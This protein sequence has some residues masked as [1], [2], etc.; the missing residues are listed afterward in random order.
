MKT[1]IIPVC[2]LSIMDYGEVLCQSN[3]DLIDSTEIFMIDDTE[4]I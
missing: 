4:Q 2:E 1:Y 3:Y